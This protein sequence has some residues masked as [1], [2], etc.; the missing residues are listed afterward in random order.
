MELTEWKGQ[1]TQWV[2]TNGREA[3][4]SVNGTKVWSECKWN[5][6]IHSINWIERSWIDLIHE[7]AYTA[8]SITF[9]HHFTK[10]MKVNG[11]NADCYM[12]LQCINLIDFIKLIAIEDIL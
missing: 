7:W 8:A 12:R 11:F 3:Q 2:L 1:R 4:W 10:E 5:H 6:S 9:T